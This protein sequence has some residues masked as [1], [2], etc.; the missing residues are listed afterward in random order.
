[1]NAAF[2]INTKKNPEYSDVYRKLAAAFEKKGFTA[3]VVDMGEERPLHEQFFRLRNIKPQLVI[4][5]DLAGFEMRTLQETP[6]FNIISCRMAHLIMK[7]DKET[8][9]C[10]NV[11]LNFSMFFYTADSDHAESIR[12]KY[13]FVEHISALKAL[14]EITVEEDPYVWENIADTLIKD[15]ELD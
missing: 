6:S 2:V 15:T 8:E 14:G 3:A 5:F 12:K 9:D 10:L 11:P 1:M 4:T 7:A 13:P